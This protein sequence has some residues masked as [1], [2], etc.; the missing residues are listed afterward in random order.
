MGWDGLRCVCMGGGGRRSDIWPFCVRLWLF[1]HLVTI[2]YVVGITQRVAVFSPGMLTLIQVTPVSWK[3]PQSQ[4]TYGRN[5]DFEMGSVTEGWFSD[6][7]HQS[8]VTHEVLPA[9]LRV[10]FTDISPKICTDM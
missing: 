9:R 10:Q 6:A 8:V 3:S 4:L 5:A 2:V 7:S 1:V